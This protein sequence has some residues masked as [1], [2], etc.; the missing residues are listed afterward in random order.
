MLY[1]CSSKNRKMG[2]TTKINAPE[3]KEKI[4]AEMEALNI[5]MRRVAD[6]M[7]KIE[8]VYGQKVYIVYHQ[9]D[10]PSCSLHDI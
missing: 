5:L 6:K 1:F 10:K 2:L 3:S 9:P 4:K 7:Q 8:Q